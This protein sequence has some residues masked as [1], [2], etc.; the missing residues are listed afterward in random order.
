MKVATIAISLLLAG[1]ICPAQTSEKAQEIQKLLVAMNA[2]KNV[3]ATLAAMW[4]QMTLNLKQ[5]FTKALEKDKGEKVENVDAAVGV[6]MDDLR[7]QFDVPQM[8][9]RLVVPI[10][11]QYFTAEEIH[12]IRLFYESPVGLKL[13]K[14]QPEIVQQMVTKATAMAQEIVGRMMTDSEFRAKIE[15]IL[16]NGASK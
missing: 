11:D 12:Q 15:G 3:E 14:S 8:I 5:V 7:K 2:T 1:S 6:F 16:R 13:V 9:E 4:P 10:Y